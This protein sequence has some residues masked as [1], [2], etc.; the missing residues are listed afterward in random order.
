MA[1]GGGLDGFGK[2]HAEAFHGV[3]KGVTDELGAVGVA[4]GFAGASDGV[5]E[6]FFHHEGERL[7]VLASWHGFG[8]HTEKEGR[9]QLFSCI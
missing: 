6:V 8:K 7:L 2:V 1:G 9:P 4:G 3:E 5:E